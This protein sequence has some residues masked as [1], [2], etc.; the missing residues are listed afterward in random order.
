MKKTVNQRQVELC[1]THRIRL[2]PEGTSDKLVCPVCVQ[3]YN[4][5]QLRRRS[6]RR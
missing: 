5:E 1:A 6:R 3:M 2:I 4:Q